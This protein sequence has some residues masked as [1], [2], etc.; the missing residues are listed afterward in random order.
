M[1]EPLTD[2]ADERPLTPRQVAELLGLHVH[3][4]KRLSPADLP[5]FVVGPRRD[6]RY[7]RADVA[8]YLAA[9]RVG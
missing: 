5:Y 1:A 9:R 6:R 4:V 3:T 7:A 8:A 2:Q